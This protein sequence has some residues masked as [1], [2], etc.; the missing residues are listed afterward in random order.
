MRAVPNPLVIMTSAMPTKTDTKATRPKSSGK[1]SR[2]RIMAK[3]ERSTCVPIR[4][5]KL[6]MKAV[7]VFDLRFMSTQIKALDAPGA[8]E[9]VQNWQ[10]RGLQEG[11]EEGGRGW[12]R[13]PAS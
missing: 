4:S 13:S 1:S 6:Q 2:A 11:G 12:Q 7:A 8:A 10:S 5:M 3:T 9:S